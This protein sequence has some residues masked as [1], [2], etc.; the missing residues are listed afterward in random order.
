ML[1]GLSAGQR[2]LWFLDRLYGSD[3]TYNMARA[4][5]LGGCLS[6]KALARSVEFL[7]LRHG[8]LRTRF[9]FHDGEPLQRIDE[10]MPVPVVVHPVRDRAELEAALKAAA[11]A[12]FDLSTGPLLR[13][14]LYALSEDEHVLLLVLHHIVSD[15]WSMGVLYRELSILYEAESSG[16]QG[17]LAPL[18]LQYADYA[19]WQRERL[20]GERLEREL[21]YWRE[22]LAGVPPVL[23]LPTDRPR[24][25]VRSGRGGQVRRRVSP[26]LLDGLRG[27]SRSRR[28]TLF[29]TLLSVFQ[30][31]LYRYTGRE[32]IVVGTP[33][34]GRD[35]PEFADLIGFFV[36][37]L[38]LRGDLSGSPSFLELLDR[39]RGMALDAYDHQALPFER[40]VEALNPPRDA[41]YSPVF[42]VM[43]VLQNAPG[44]ELSLGDLRL[45]RVEVS[46]E[47]SKFDLLLSMTESA[48][49]LSLVFEYDAD[50][51]D[52]TTIER[53]GGHYERLLGS[54]V[55]EA[56][57]PIWQLPM[58]SEEERQQLLVEWNDTGMAYPR[59]QTVHGLFSAQA[60]RRPESVA[61]IYQDE[62]VS[63]G[64]LDRRS[65][66][67]AHRLRGLG[68]GPEV[69]VGICV[70]RSLEMVV[71]ILGI[72]K[73]GGAY[74]PLDPAYPPSR[75]AYM[76]EDT[77]APVLV[78]QGRFD[79]LFSEVKATRVD[80][81]GFDWSVP[82]PE[83][84]L[85]SGVGADNLVY[86]M[87]TSGSTGQ[88]KGVQ[89]EHRSV[90]HLFA[91]TAR[92]FQFGTRDVW[93]LFHAYA[94]DF[95]VWEMWGALL[96][97]GRLVVV[98]YLT[99]RSPQAFL[100]LVVRQGVT[101]LNQTPSAFRQLLAVETA[102]HG[103]GTPGPLAALR[104]LV[105]GGEALE[106]S[107]LGP[108]FDRYGNTGPQLA[109]MYGLT[110]STV[111]VTFQNL[112][113]ALL[114]QLPRNLIGKAIPGLSVRVF[115]LHGSPVPI[116]V[117]G[118]LHVSGVGLARGYL[119][120][121]E[122]TAER[123]I[124][125]PFSEVPGQRL[126]RTGDLVRCRP[127]GNLEFLGR[128]DQ[129]V[130][131][132]GFRIELG[133]IESVLCQHETVSSCAVV[134]RADT[135]AGDQLVAYVVGNV[136]SG[137]SPAELRA[138]LRNRLP[139]HMVPTAFVDLEQLP[140][141]VN[142]KLDRDALPDPGT[143][144]RA[145]GA[146]YVGARTPVEE[147]LAEIW[148][149]MLGIERVGVEDNL[150]DLG[151][152]SLLAVQILNRVQDVLI[153]DLPLIR[154]FE[155]P[156][157]SQLA[158]LVESER[159]GAQ[160]SMP[161]PGGMVR[162][163]DV[164]LSY[165]QRRLWFLDHFR[166]SDAGYHI[167]TA[168]GLTGSPNLGALERS[169]EALVACH[170]S[171]RTRF[172]FHDGEPLQRIDESMPVPVVVHPVRDRA[173]L[174]A[175]LKAAAAAPFDLSTGPL[176]RVCLYALSEDEHVLLLV[177]HH[178]VSDGWSMGVLYR[179]LSIL[180]EA[181]SSGRQGQL[182]PLP[183]Q[184]A[185][186][187]LWQRERLT[188]ER[189]ERELGYWR[190]RLAGVPPVLELPTDRPRPKVRSGRGGQVR[191][192]VSP[193]LLDGLR[194]L[195][196]SRRC[197]LFMTLLSVFQVLLYRYTGRE[198]IVVGTPTAGRDRPEFADLIGFFVN[199][200]VL[201][202]DL[203]GSPSFLELLDRTR[204]MAL[205]AYDHQA[206]PFERLVEALN[207]PRDASYSPVFQVM[208][209]LQNA[210]GGEL[211]LGDLRLSR[212][213]VSTET[214]KFDLLLSM[215]ESADGLSLVFEYDADLFDQTTIERMGGHYERLLGSVVEEAC[216][217]IWQLPMLSEEERQQ[218][219]VEWNDTGMAYPREQTVHG[220]FSAQAQRRPESVALIY[221]DES[222]S[223]G[224][225]DRR[226]TLLAH[227][228]RG[229]GVGP[230]VLVGICVERSLEMV[231]GILG[232]LKAGG[233]YV[234]LD[235]A[236]PPS[237]LAYMLEDT[238]APVLVL[239]GRFDALFSEVKATRVDLD[240]FDWSVPLPEGTLDS[241]VGADN[242]V[243][244]M[245][246]SG[247]TGQPKGVMIP[248]RG[249][250]RLT[251]ST[252]YVALGPSTVVMHLAPASF[253]ASTFE[254]WSALLNGGRC[255]LHP[256]IR[257]TVDSLQALIEREA[258]NTLWLTAS[259]FNVIVAEAPVALAQA[260]QILIGGESL[261]VSHV[262]EALSELSG[263]RLINGYGPTEGT[264]FSCCYPIPTD[265]ADTSISIPIG[266]PIAHTCAYILDARREPVPIGVSGEL[267]IGGDGL[268]RGYLNRPD[269][270]AERFVA[271]HIGAEPGARLYRTGDLARYRPD[272]RIEFL[273][274]ID[275]QVKL[276]GFRI[277]LGE[278]EAV[279]GQHEAVAGCA[280]SLEDRGETT[281]RLLAY[282]VF[283]TRW[284]GASVLS[285]V[286]WHLRERLPAYMIPGTFVLLDELP[287]TENGKLNR[288]ALTGLSDAAPAAIEMPSDE[289]DLVL[290]SVVET[291]KSVLNLD[292]LDPGS[293]FFALGGNSLLAIELTHRIH[294]HLGV[295][296][297]LDQ[298][299]LDCA[300]PVRIAD[301][302]RNQQDSDEFDVAV[303]LQKGNGGRSLFCLHTLGGDIFHYI[304]L[305]RALDN[306]QR[307]VGIRLRNVAPQAE[308]DFDVPSIASR[309]ADAIRKIQPFGPY[310]LC[311]WSS[312]GVIAMEVARLL[313]EEETVLI[314]IDSYNSTS[315]RRPGVA[316]RAAALVRR[317][318]NKVWDY[319]AA[320]IRA[321]GVL[322][323][324]R[325]WAYS[326]YQSGPY[327]HRFLLIRS[328]HSVGA[329][330]DACLGWSEV[331]QA[332]IDLE[333]VLGD[334]ETMM[335][336]PDV[337]QTAEIV[338][339][340]LEQFTARSASAR[341]SKSV[342]G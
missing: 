10:S 66:L 200:L 199:T 306:S 143:E 324:R 153:V 245:Y 319:P 45:S 249:V 36:N 304:P 24:P 302:I 335:Q 293:D 167:A 320:T 114:D 158:A 26:G 255:V 50:L 120:L 37:T 156:T 145:L 7:V 109:N 287:R 184:Y 339:R 161:A 105:L 20:T 297:P 151:G 87:Y 341:D 175:A 243:Y 206:L 285:T 259:F 18:P 141:T 299:W 78:L 86:V 127:D 84:T 178:I 168:Y 115:D 147:V 101:V 225:L 202:G 321:R 191:R 170:E 13:V 300:S 179:E 189:L 201:R 263:A 125:D 323:L 32:D 330:G 325:F 71:G 180:Y 235:P 117:P 278:I 75:L 229:L 148:R 52:Q 198:D 305:V 22:R 273:G 241:G 90:V 337:N 187:A 246:T 38:V 3:S 154:L 35:R 280:V 196:R 338:Q 244:V 139:E 315:Q 334:H 21:G 41:S 221:Q 2:R 271:D 290:R 118:E 146:G 282:L 288:E 12:P 230:E 294:Q 19:L 133:E 88:P 322:F 192:R 48:D 261:S 248:H 232:I 128:I 328:S 276:R 149:E 266:R 162:P 150:F 242:L 112:D 240:G 190:E 152:H 11:A 39:T 311:G 269:L 289:S 77:S 216:R 159:N 268:A 56:C 217:P 14:C 264:T 31:L 260:K 121:P 327:A 124:E 64:E 100:D 174:E 208:M 164:P 204:G 28:C 131:L 313:G 250:V 57:R 303:E 253:D 106:P 177:L 292:A 72:L 61:L 68:V 218:L 89:I 163:A 116:G 279:L 95:S 69:L 135:Q 209:V 223:Y 30:V 318:M 67:L 307:V 256:N 51:F 239:Q 34:A 46:T 219:L 267:Y 79:A 210:P 98:P 274:R 247:S 99:S 314:M 76:L 155:G 160:A 298:L 103:C 173:E 194:G 58:L 211:S 126:Y 312:G 207:P 44:G 53:M 165:A 296:L 265:L 251:Q 123:F 166:G 107:D 1:T 8:S 119:N 329:T 336:E 332:G 96:H 55:E 340:Y 111:H 213:E 27:L 224:E 63:Y 228:L 333:M 157:V 182:A 92:W 301:H 94:F 25:K 60:Q 6:V 238:S 42:Q 172:E 83:G 309:A 270:T 291:M 281:A 104:W 15:G 40:L 176:L 331:A 29:M 283:K 65:T 295:R 277:E 102:G 74:V 82:L 137:I 222:V 132:R 237:R 70:E 16:R 136:G 59:E 144:H 33:T 54:V 183:L 227:R 203:S 186:Y 5:R 236:Y 97:G 220:L 212:V 23:E 193:G 49:G 286:G 181:E 257:P 80:L 205:D 171:L 142:G 231:V 43:M 140:L 130:K 317:I 91:A 110:E 214:S 122:L 226:S 188:G 275:Q 262:R 195:S 108:W 233:A 258:I 326:G 47:T 308:A 4:F 234:P 252:D 254:L 310:L 73:A 138:H 129:Q 215:T 17:Q 342:F 85:D 81:D 197:T 316:K 9:E 93:T 284:K 134:L 62:S 169:I 113:P 272:G 185:D